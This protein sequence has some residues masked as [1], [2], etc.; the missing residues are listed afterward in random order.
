MDNVLT[1]CSND[2]TIQA[3]FDHQPDVN[4]GNEKAS[5]SILYKAVQSGKLK[6]VKVCYGP[7]YLFI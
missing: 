2:I 6:I 1:A 4:L 3:I 5:H 7:F